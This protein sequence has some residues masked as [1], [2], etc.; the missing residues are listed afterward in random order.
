[1]TDKKTQLRGICQ[2]C[3]REQAVLASGRMSKHGYTVEHG[4]FSGVCS[5]QH[6]QPLQKDRDQAD[7]I[8]ANV[9]AE[10]LVLLQKADAYRTGVLTP[11]TVQGHWD[12]KVRDYAQIAWAD[13]TAYQRAGELQRVTWKLTRRAEQGT[14]FADQL[15]A[16]ANRVF[17]TE[18][19]VVPVE[20]GPAPIRFGEQRKNDKGVVL[21]VTGVRGARVH[22]S[23]TKAD[24]R[25][26][27][28]WT[29]T[30][31]WRRLAT[32]D[33]AGAAG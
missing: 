21:T 14:S 8:V 23:M 5:G 7:R 1:M 18:L 31:A 9:R 30:Q 26:F 10:V 3:G 16:T 33:E 6:F 20:S 28:G 11:E 22:W 32:V 17:G 27:N 25:V 24:G 15:E 29:G 19:R 13:A 2:C 12:A 4:W